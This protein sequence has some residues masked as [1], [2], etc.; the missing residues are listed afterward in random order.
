[1]A[2]EPRVPSSAY[3]IGGPFVHNF[4]VIFWNDPPPKSFAGDLIRQKDLT[5]SSKPWAWMLGWI[6]ATK[7]L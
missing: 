7:V 6:S 1:M 2:G 5:C 3:F 4:V